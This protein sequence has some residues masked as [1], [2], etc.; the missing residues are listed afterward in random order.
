MSEVNQKHKDKMG[1][2]APGRSPDLDAR[3]TE[4]R[5]LIRNTRAFLEGLHESEQQTKAYLKELAESLERDLERLR[6]KA[7]D[8]REG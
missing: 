5:E 8:R 1:V 6:K 4:T 7:S 3:I 2:F